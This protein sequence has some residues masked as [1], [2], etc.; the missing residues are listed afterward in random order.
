[1]HPMP[2]LSPTLPTLTMLLLLPPA[3]PPSALH[4]DALT[5]G[6]TSGSKLAEATKSAH[7]GCQHCSGNGAK[8][9]LYFS[10]GRAY[11]PVH[12]VSANA[13]IGLLPSP[14]LRVCARSTRRAWRALAVAPSIRRTSRSQPN[15]RPLVVGASCRNTRSVGTLPASLVARVNAWRTRPRCIS[16]F[17]LSRRRFLADAECSGLLATP[18]SVLPLERAILVYE[19]MVVEAHCTARATAC[20]RSSAFTEHTSIL[21]LAGSTAATPRRSVERRS[22]QNSIATETIS[23]C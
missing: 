4:Q 13:T 23:A 3:A 16:S 9:P 18:L 5:H 11:G 12:G 22:V 2:V 20:S 6:D 21:R 10:M 19:A 7:W 15:V 14:S 8:A 17:A 1:M